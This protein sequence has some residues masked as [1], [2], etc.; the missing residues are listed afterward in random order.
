MGGKRAGTSHS[1]G[2][3][4]KPCFVPNPHHSHFCPFSYIGIPFYRIVY[5]KRLSFHWS[6][7][8][9]II[10]WG[11]YFPQG[12]GIEGKLEQNTL[13]ARIQISNNPK[14]FFSTQV[15]GENFEQKIAFNSF[16]SEFSKYYFKQY[17]EE[18]CLDSPSKAK[19]WPSACEGRAWEQV[20]I[21]WVELKADW[22]ILF[23]RLL[24]L[25]VIATVA[26]P[27]RQQSL[28]T[29]HLYCARQEPS[30]LYELSPTTHYLV[31]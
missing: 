6:L 26:T 18:T 14:R 7:E 13:Y 11:L 30:P 9:V 12:E 8:F 24:L 2:L 4:T 10:E 16:S 21:F 25:V 22:L 27:P 19:H 23:L 31:L 1:H 15:M 20:C 17:W 28:P 5:Q 29:E 3:Q